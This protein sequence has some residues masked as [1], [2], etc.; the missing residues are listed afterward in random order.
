M[1]TIMSCG[2]DVSFKKLIIP[3]IQFKKSGAYG[4]LLFPVCENQMIVMISIAMQI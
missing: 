2:I 4:L 3:V 1:Q